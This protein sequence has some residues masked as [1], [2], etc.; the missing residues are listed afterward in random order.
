ML[1]IPKYI[2]LAKKVKLSEGGKILDLSLI[3][4]ADFKIMQN[5]TM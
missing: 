3:S 1:N 5:F 2:D 4:F